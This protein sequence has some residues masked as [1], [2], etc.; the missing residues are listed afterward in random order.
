[1]HD[2]QRGFSPSFDAWLFENAL[3]LFTS[4]H[5]EHFFIPPSTRLNPKI[6]MNASAELLIPSIS[7]QCTLVYSNPPHFVGG[8]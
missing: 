1:M 8:G 6:P 4:P 5:F 7:I 3:S 2:L